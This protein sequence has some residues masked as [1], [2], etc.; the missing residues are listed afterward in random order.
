M[1]RG[2]KLPNYYPENLDKYINIIKNN[3]INS[4]IMI[5]CSHENSNKNY[6]NQ[7]YVVESIINQIKNGN[8]YINGIMLESNI[9]EGN[10]DIN[11]IKYGISI[12]D[13][14]IN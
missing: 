11:N 4:T 2:G 10:Q 6:L 12:T 9:N 1:L 8:S 13:S 14:C 3:N 5:D 7:I